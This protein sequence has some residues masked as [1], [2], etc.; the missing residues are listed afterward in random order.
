MSEK[1]LTGDVSSV[2]KH[3]F[4]ESLYSTFNRPLLLRHAAPWEE[5]LG[6]HCWL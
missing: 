4:L 2:G 1:D 3:F 5:C 6:S